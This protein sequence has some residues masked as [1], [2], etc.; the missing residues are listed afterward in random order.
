[1]V[2]VYEWEEKGQGS[3]EREVIVVWQQKSETRK[4]E[5]LPVNKSAP[6]TACAFALVAS[7]PSPSFLSSFF[8]SSRRL[9]SFLL[10]S[11]SSPSPPTSP[12]E[13]PFRYLITR[14]L[15]AHSLPPCTPPTLVFIFESTYLSGSPPQDP[16]T[17][18]AAAH[19]PS[20]GSP[21]IQELWSIAAESFHW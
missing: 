13:G 11:H 9:L 2:V 18:A 16:F 17:L 5:M 7:S 6:L 12:I 1:M 20:L 8:K 10:S 21:I 19:Q 14:I 15:V 3:G 4:T